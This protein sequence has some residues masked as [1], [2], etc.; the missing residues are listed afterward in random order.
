MKD[1]KNFT[2]NSLDAQAIK[3]AASGREIE[4]L[5]HVAG[6]N[7]ERLDGKHHD[8][9]KCGGNDRFRCMVE[10]D[11]K[12]VICNQCFSE[13][14]GDVIAAVMHYR[15]VTFP[16]ALRLI[17]DYLGGVAAEPFQT[18]KRPIPS[19]HKAG[20]ISARAKKQSHETPLRT[21]PF[22]YL[23]GVGDYHVKVERLEFADGSKSFRQYHWD[24]D[25]QCYVVG[26]KGVTPV[27]WDAPSF[28]EA[29]IIFW[30]EGEKAAAT[31]GRVMAN[32][33]PDVCCSCN[34]GGS[35]NFPAELVPWFAGK[36][37]VIFADNDRPGEAYARKVA[38][39]ITGTAKSVRVVFFAESMQQG[40]DVADWLTE[41]SEV[42]Q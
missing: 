36:E 29:S 11:G 15:E 17:G 19:R 33:K 2:R 24:V 7:I 3:A 13:N 16:E 27:P 25:R 32:R 42:L 5:Q 41:E 9:P 31:L 37:V 12:P 26:T 34:W 21:I 10:R 22:E 4:I 40:Y 20:N 35:K 14:N 18:I 1:K 28:K 6:I 39:A 38:L 23:N 8:C 30:C